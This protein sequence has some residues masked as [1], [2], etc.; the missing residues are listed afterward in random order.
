MKVKWLG[1]ASALIT[2]DSGLKIL[3]DPYQPGYHARPD[4]ILFYANI[5]EKVDIVVISHEHPDH[6]YMATV[7]GNPAIVRGSEIRG[8]SPVKVK[9]IEFKGVATLHDDVGGQMMG[10]NCVTCFEVDGLKVCH[11]GDI[12][13]VLTDEQVSE[14]GKVDVLLLLIGLLKGLGGKRV[15]I[16]EKGQTV[17]APY[18]AYMIDA[19]IANRVL[20]QISPRVTIPIHYSNARCSFKL[21]GVDTFLIDKKNVVRPNVSEVELKQGKLPEE[22]QIIVLNPAL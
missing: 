3:T 12:G 13:H 6:A 8:E 10:D 21:C 18:K 5:T 11:S 1:H 14:I 17:P 9:G 19:D 16:N 2:S 7:Q 20:E 4:G 15:T 22:N